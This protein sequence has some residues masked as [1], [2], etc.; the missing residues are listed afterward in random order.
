MWNLMN[1]IAASNVVSESGPFCTGITSHASLCIVQS[2]L[3]L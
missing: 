2:G 1:I 3:D